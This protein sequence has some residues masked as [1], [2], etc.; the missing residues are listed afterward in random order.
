MQNFEAAN[1]QYLQSLRVESTQATFQWLTEL[2]TPEPRHVAIMRAAWSLAEL[3]EEAI[4]A[5][6]AQDGFDSVFR[7]DYELADWRDEFDYG[8]REP[9]ELYQLAV[10]L[11]IGAARAWVVVRAG[12]RGAGV[13]ELVGV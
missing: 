5:T 1:D 10:G 4:Q 8:D 7:H 9:D 3:G 2:K 11:V 12:L 13:G 6:L